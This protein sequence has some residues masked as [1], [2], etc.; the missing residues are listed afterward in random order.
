[1]FKIRKVL[2]H[3]YYRTLE[4][5]IMERFFRVNFT[6]EITT[7]KDT[8]AVVPQRSVLGPA[9]YLTYTSDLPTSD[10]TTATSADDTAI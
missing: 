2:S 10:N 6:D 7:S 8:E 4:S 5:Y 9:L 3:A 1:M